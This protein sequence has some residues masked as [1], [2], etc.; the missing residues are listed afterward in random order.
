M[1]ALLP[2]IASSNN[3]LKGLCA[4]LDWPAAGETARLSWIA[5][6]M[7]QAWDACSDSI[8]AG[9]NCVASAPISSSLSCDKASA[10]VDSLQNFIIMWFRSNLRSQSPFQ[11]LTTSGRPAGEMLGRRRHSSLSSMLCRASRLLL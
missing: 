10:L 9:C 1:A 11:F 6:S 3:Q 5:Q 8:N 7:L 2:R 4:F